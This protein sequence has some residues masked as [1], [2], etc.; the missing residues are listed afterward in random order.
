[1]WAAR[2][3][4]SRGGRDAGAC[5]DD[6]A[7]GFSGLDVLSNG[8]EAALPER[9]RRS[10]IADDRRMFLAH[11]AAVWLLRLLSPLRLSTLCSLC[12]DANIRAKIVSTTG[13]VVPLAAAAAGAKA[14][15][16][17]APFPYFGQPAGHGG[18]TGWTCGEAGNGQMS[19]V[20][21]EAGSVVKT[22]SVG[23]RESR[24]SRGRSKLHHPRHHQAGTLDSRC[25][26]N[27]YRCRDCSEFSI[28]WRGRVGERGTDGKLNVDPGQPSQHAVICVRPLR[29]T[30]H[31]QPLRDSLQSEL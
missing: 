23:I 27:A 25:D 7:A 19:A 8:C 11:F 15:Q 16:V 4:T 26:G 12:L 21:L 18:S 13:I 22:K 5:H 29:W 14:L 30:Q 20:E 31:I 10:V 9:L 1:L 6:D 24:I 2:R 17:M 3:H 28:A